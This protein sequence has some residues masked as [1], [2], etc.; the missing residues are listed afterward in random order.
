[1]RA[2]NAATIETAM[3]VVAGAAGGAAADRI[4]DCLD[5]EPRIKANAEGPS[6]VR[7]AGGRLAAPPEAPGGTP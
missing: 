4:F 3:N 6:I 1:M 7:E 5:R 2:K